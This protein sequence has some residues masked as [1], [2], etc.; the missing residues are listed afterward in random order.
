MEPAESGLS[1]EIVRPRLVFRWGM[2]KAMRDLVAV[3]F[4]SVIAACDPGW[5]IQNPGTADRPIDL[6][7]VEAGI[8]AWSPKVN[9]SPAVHGEAISLDAASQT[10]P[11]FTM[12]V[13]WRKKDPNKLEL[14]AY[15]LGTEPPPGV[16]DAYRSS[17]EAVAASVG[18]ACQATITL[19]PESCQRCK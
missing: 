1:H 14:S 12:H 18:N 4:V 15:A 19:G 11:V 3:G 9:S 5:N 13:Y 8:R 7:C 16:L 2:M 17:R 10:T 6:A